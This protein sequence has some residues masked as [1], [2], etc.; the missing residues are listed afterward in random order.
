M[1]YNKY[2]IIAKER[3]YTITPEG[4]V[5]NPK[6]KQIGTY[7]KNKYMYFS[8]R[9]NGKIVKVYFHRY[10]AYLKF[11]N[12]LYEDGIMV[13]HLDGDLLNNSVSNIELGTNSDNM[14]DISKEK[15]IQKSAN[16]NKKYSDDLVLEIKADR[17]RGMS[18]KDLMEKYHISSKGTISNIIN[19]R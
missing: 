14:L 10:Q 6:G 17:E 18:Y 19:K 15:R 5:F 2:E 1:E 13:R 12:S 7:G 3:G 11:G 4:V 8:F 9:L 16:A